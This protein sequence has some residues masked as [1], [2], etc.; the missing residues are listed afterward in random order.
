MDKAGGYDVLKKL[1]AKPA[2]PE[3]EAQKRDSKVLIKLV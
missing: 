1:R 2:T 3:T